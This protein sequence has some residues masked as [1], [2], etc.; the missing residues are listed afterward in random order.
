M[1]AARGAGTRARC[2]RTARIPYS[3]DVPELAEPDV[4]RGKR[5]GAG[6]GRDVA[7]QREK[8]PTVRSPDSRLDEP[9]AMKPIHTTGGRKRRTEVGTAH[10]IVPLELRRQNVDNAR[11]RLL[12]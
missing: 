4:D 6:P 9:S 11:A 2:H 3:V 10:A 5:G 12:R 1:G 7:E 8:D